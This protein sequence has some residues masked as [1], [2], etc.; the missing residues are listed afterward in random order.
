MKHAIRIATFFI[1]IYAISTWATGQNVYKCGSSYSQVPCTD[2]IVL[3]ASDPRTPAQKAETDSAAR[4]DLATANAMEK[5]R[6]KEEA[7]LRAAQAKQDK[8]QKKAIAP[9]PAS[10]DAPSETD[11][12]ASTGKKDKKSTAKKN[13][14]EP[15]FFTAKGEPTSK[16]KP[17]TPA[18]GTR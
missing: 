8:A 10:R 15:E 13:H 14:K 9:S 16:P 3:D 7:R 11:H 18:S 2:A 6:L 4:R 12:T 5:A 17:K 1:A